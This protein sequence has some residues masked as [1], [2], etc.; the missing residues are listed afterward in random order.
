MSEE[1]TE[2]TIEIL[3]DV[4]CLACLEQLGLHS[5]EITFLIIAGSTLLRF[6]VDAIRI[7]IKEKSRTQKES[8]K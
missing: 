5:S 4:S 3:T 8:D 6:I 7:R 2:S 1:S